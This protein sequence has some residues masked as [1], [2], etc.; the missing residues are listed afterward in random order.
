MAKSECSG[1]C[2]CLS[3]S[4]KS[5]FPP[6]QSFPGSLISFQVKV[7]I[8]F[9]SEALF[10]MSKLLDNTWEKATS[11]SPSQKH[12]GKKRASEFRMLLMPL[13]HEWCFNGTPE[14]L[15][16]SCCLEGIRLLFSLHLGLSLVFQVKQF[17]QKLF[18]NCF[19]DPIFAPH[20]R[21]WNAYVLATRPAF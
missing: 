2:F 19:R 3:T 4:P 7:E 17:G 14:L 6:T 15:L 16:S 1:I 9:N 21:P 5:F 8:Y 10:F 18:H 20:W 11:S 13:V 12:Y